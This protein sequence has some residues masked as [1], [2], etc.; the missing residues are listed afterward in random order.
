MSTGKYELAVR[1]LIV[2][3]EEVNNFFR[4]LLRPLTDLIG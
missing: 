3:D 2:N 4:G 1:N